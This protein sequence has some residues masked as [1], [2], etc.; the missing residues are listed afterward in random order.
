[1]ADSD[2]IQ[3]KI[4]LISDLHGNL[5]AT[6]AVDRDLNARKPD[7][8]WCLGDIVGKGPSS[9]ETFD[10]AMSRCSLILRGNWDE[11]IGL[12]QFSASDGYYYS[13]LGEER[14]KKLANLPAEHSAW[15]SGRHV[16]LIHGRPVMKKLLSA[17]DPEEKLNWLFEPD[18]DTVGFGDIHHPGLR[19][20]HGN[21]LL[22]SLG[23]VGNSIRVPL[24]QY[25]ILTCEEGG[26]KACFDLSFICLPYDTDRAVRDAENSP[27]LPHREAYIRE[28]TTGIY[29]RGYNKSADK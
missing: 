23:S 4:A 12:K 15:L 25:A 3:M 26:D 22:F 13:Q 6:E 20:L 16:R 1:M 7:A 18:Y 9:A 24:A 11:G 2:G 27:G 21:R 17:H 19:A 8:V 5:P 14:M 10:W 29:S 28:I